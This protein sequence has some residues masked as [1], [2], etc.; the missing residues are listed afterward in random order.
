MEYRKQFKGQTETDEHLKLLCHIR[1]EYTNYDKL[2]GYYNLYIDKRT[3]LNTAITKL[4][5]RGPDG[6]DS[7]RKKVKAIEEYVDITK[8]KAKQRFINEQIVR[9]RLENPDYTVAFAKKCA[10]SML[11]NYIKENNLCNS[12][13]NKIKEN[14]H[15]ESNKN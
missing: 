12:K 15:G 3:E 1:H 4:I 8:K 5:R 9:I 11:A 6:I 7:F 14:D 13:R 10:K 2:M